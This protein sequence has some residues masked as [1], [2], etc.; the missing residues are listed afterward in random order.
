M[1]SE[2]PSEI[3][4]VS[5]WHL[6]NVSIDQLAIDLERVLGRGRMRPSAQIRRLRA[7]DAFTLVKIVCG[8]VY[9]QK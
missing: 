5:N 1:Q 7:P 2:R 8:S 3:I 9:A 4:V 6:I